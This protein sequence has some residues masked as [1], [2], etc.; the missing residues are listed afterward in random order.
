MSCSC[1]LVIICMCPLSVELGGGSVGGQRTCHT[2]GRQRH[3][4]STGIDYLSQ[5][6]LS[7][8]PISA[9]SC[10]WT[11]QVLT[12]DFDMYACPYIQRNPQR[13]S[14]KRSTGR[15]MTITCASKL[16]GTGRFHGRLL[17]E[18]PAQSSIGEASPR[19]CSNISTP[20]L[21]AAW[22][23]VSASTDIVPF[24]SNPYTRRR[25]SKRAKSSG[26][27]SVTFAVR[28]S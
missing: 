12:R 24:S 23:S 10:R 11:G 13:L 6:L 9:V 18:L 16:K 14:S 8:T 4:H 2:E 25:S 28:F 7:P 17:F 22:S 3:R 21:N 1:I 27:L 19:N 26:T 20:H 5:S 15:Q